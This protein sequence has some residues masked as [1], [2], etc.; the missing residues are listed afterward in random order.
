[1]T[2]EKDEKEEMEGQVSAEEAPRRLGGESAAAPSQ[3]AL[4]G[5]QVIACAVLI[6]MFV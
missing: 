1:M 3:P 5:K 2:E 6:R 4:T